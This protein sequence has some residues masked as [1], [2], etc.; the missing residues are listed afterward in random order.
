MIR[1][2]LDE[3]DFLIKIDPKDAYFGIPLDKTSDIF[4]FNGTEFL[5]LCFVLGPAPKIFLKLLKIPIALIR[6]INVRIIIFLNDMLVMAQTLKELIHARKS[7]IFAL[8]K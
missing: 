5:C 6:R 7:L 2:L 8:Q 4:V 3:N 1:Y